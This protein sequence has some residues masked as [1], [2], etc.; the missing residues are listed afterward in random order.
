MDQL[1]NKKAI[2]F[3]RF[4][5]KKSGG[6]PHSIISMSKLFSNEVSFDVFSDD[7]FFKNI[8]KNHLKEKIAKNKFTNHYDLF[9]ICGSWQIN[10][11]FKLLIA[12]IG[13]KK[14]IY[15][16]K[17][18]LAYYEFSTYKIVY[19]LPFF[20][21]YEL[22]KILLAHTIVYSSKLEYDNSIVKFFTN[23]KIIIH[24]YYKL[25]KNQA[26]NFK[27]K[28]TLNIG[29]IGQYSHR[30]SLIECI[31]AIDILK[32]KFL[33]HSI[34]LNIAGDALNHR[35]QTKI[36]NIISTLN[37]TQHI[38]FVGYLDNKEKVKFFKKNKIILIPSKFESYSL[39][40]A[41]AFNYGALPVM[42]KNIG[43]T[44]SCSTKFFK[45]NHISPISIASAITKMVDPVNYDA[46]LK[47]RSSIIRKLNSEILHGI[48]KIKN[49]INDGYQ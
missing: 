11:F 36:N 33:K 9:L 35:Y 23:K 39:V 13:N 30:K 3:S 12:K 38:K 14:I 6:I 29:F 25:L 7:G 45:I 31:L 43:I 34:C 8:S 15:F 49:L 2:I 1:Q 46:I 4:F 5:N 44:E 21:F 22:P 48:K 32:K 20:F 42:S 18:N 41:E 37:L 28:Q 17:G 10:I 27:F 40:V 24:D 16:P 19:K 47:N 26:A